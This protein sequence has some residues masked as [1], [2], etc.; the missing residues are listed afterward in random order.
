MRS[1]GWH[2]SRGGWNGGGTRMRMRWISGMAV[3]AFAFSAQGETVFV[4]DESANVVHVIVAPRWQSAGDIATGRRPRGIVLSR[5]RKHLYVA[6][7]DD[8]RID[9]IDIATR[10][11]VDHLPSGPDPE[12]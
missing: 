6:A 5:D 12:R 8:D 10:K 2:C 9:V 1:P 4:S 3:A 11:V 7:G